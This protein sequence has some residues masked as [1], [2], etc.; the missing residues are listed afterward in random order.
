MRSVHSCS[1]CAR[2]KG[3][4]T[5]PGQE[6]TRSPRAAHSQVTLQGLVHST[7]GMS[8]QPTDELFPAGLEAAPQT[9]TAQ[10]FWLPM[11]EA[12]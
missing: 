6:K 5:H 10:R 7:C 3:V 4:P 9:L 8:A 1:W 2:E 11:C 12:G